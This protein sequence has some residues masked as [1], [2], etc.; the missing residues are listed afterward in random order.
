MGRQAVRPTGLKTDYER[1][2]IA[3][4]PD[5]ASL[6]RLAAYSTSS[7]ASS[8]DAC[9]VSRS[10]CLSTV[11]ADT[12]APAARLKATPYDPADLHMT[13]A[14][15]G[16]IDAS[17]IAAILSQLPDIAKPLPT[18]T[19][20]GEAWWP[21]PSKPRVHVIRYGQPD[22]LKGL[23]EAVQTLAR[24]LSLPVD[25]RPFRPHITLGRISAA[26]DSGP[27]QARSGLFA[28]RTAL[29]ARMQYIG[30]FCQNKEGG[31]LRY[32]LLGQFALN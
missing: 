3:L 18:L 22:A 12:A 23:F 13:L 21:K 5:P 30:L 31:V 8:L 2:F 32:R 26:K 11:M 25:S 27:P 9:S 29:N 17:H 4:V 20:I 19:C 14:F 10:V 6:S 15:L 24:S 16:A 7:L 28:T 1:A